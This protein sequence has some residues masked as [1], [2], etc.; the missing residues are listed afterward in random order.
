M[1]A[2]VV[3]VLVILVAVGGAHSGGL[4][5]IHAFL[6]VVEAVGVHAR[7]VGGTEFV[8]C[9]VAV[10]VQEAV[11]ACCVCAGRFYRL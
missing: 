6:C 11:D 9:C 4:Q 3:V 8:G 2:A 1:R 5:D 7:V 10:C